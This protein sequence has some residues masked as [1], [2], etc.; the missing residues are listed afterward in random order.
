MLL[1]S[2]VTV[3]VYFPCAL[4][5]TN[6]SFLQWIPHDLGSKRFNCTD[7]QLGVLAKRSLILCGVMTE[8][9][10]HTTVREAKIGIETIH[11]QGGIFG[12]VADSEAFVASLVLVEELK[13]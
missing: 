2:Y 5:C 10:V 1:G 7:F 8:V 6:S 13:E 12:S 4:D 11:A 3:V 9:C